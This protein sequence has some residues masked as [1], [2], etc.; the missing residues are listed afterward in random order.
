MKDKQSR[1]CPSAKFSKGSL[2][3]GVRNE[4]EEMDILAE[5]LKITQDIYEAFKST[6]TKPEKTLRVANKCIESG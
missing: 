3:I 4:E 5:P 6:D 2:L 1:T